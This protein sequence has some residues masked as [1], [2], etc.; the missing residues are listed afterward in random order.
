MLVPPLHNRKT[1]RDRVVP[2]LHR[3]FAGL[4]CVCAVFLSIFFMTKITKCNTC[5]PPFNKNIPIILN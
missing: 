1:G 2:Q 5:T 3:Y 4:F